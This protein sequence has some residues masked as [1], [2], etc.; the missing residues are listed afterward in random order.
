MRN[1]FKKDGW[2]FIKEIVDEFGYIFLMLCFY[3]DIM[4]L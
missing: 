2:E 1:L 3:E 4:I